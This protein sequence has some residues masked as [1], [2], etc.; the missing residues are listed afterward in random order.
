M[1]AM[2]TAWRWDR[3]DQ[4][5]DGRY[6][7]IEGLNQVRVALDRYGM[8]VADWHAYRTAR[9]DLMPSFSCTWPDARDLGAGRSGQAMK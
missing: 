2:V 6:W 7:G 4:L 9:P 3:D 8:D 5:P 1:R